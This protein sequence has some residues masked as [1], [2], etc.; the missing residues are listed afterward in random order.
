MARWP[1]YVSYALD[2]LLNAS[3]YDEEVARRF[4]QHWG[5]WEADHLLRAL[6]EGEEHDRLFAIFCLGQLGL[7]QDELASYLIPLLRSERPLE[8]WAAAKELGNAGRAEALAVLHA[9]LTDYLAPA[10]Q[11][12]RSGG[13]REWFYDAWRFSAARLVGELGQEASAPFV[14]AALVQVLGLRTATVGV[15]GPT[16]GDSLL[17]KADVNNWVAYIREL[18]Y[19]L[20]R[21]GALGA[22]TGIE[23]LS[24]REGME[25]LVHLVMGSLHR[26]FPAP[27]LVVRWDQVPERRDAA[28][29]ML[30][31]HFALSD[32]ERQVY[33]QTYKQAALLGR[34]AG[35][36]QMEPV[37][38]EWYK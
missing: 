9:M 17:L 12:T 7:P 26:R 6:T 23:A 34:V 14:R 38:A 21:L 10:T 24:P 31:R 5:G 13:K 30:A 3:P 37:R 18:V 27:E 29:R 35:V 8:R 33:L 11:Y 25:L 36:K 1:T 15:A 2:A 32:E 22:L 28:D 20:G 16:D 4:R 19:V